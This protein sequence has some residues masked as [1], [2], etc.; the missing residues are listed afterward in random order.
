MQHKIVITGGPGTGKSTLIYELESRGFDCVHEVSRQITLQ[1][2]E[3]GIEQLFLKDPVLF[4][5]MLLEGRVKQFMSASKNEADT[6]FFDRGIPDIVAY[7]NYMGI[8]GG[9]LFTDASENYLYYKVFITPPWKEIYITDNERYE[10]F[11]QALAIHNHLKN[12]YTVYNYE[13]S[14]VPFGT[15]D[16]RVDFILKELNMT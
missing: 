8:D 12:T 5:K 6:V 13:L 10:S 16:E 2:R 7:M 4:S 1:A 15:V 3:L 9:S 11:E 14:E